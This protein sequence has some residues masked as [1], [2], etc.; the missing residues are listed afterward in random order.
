MKYTFSKETYY[1]VPTQVWFF[2][3]Y[4]A[5]DYTDCTEWLGGIAYRDVIICGECGG[6]V[7][8]EDLFAD[9]LEAFGTDEIICPM[10]WCNISEAITGDLHAPFMDTDYDEE[11]TDDACSK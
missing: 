9:A 7:F 6:E 2:N 11:D 3:S 10:S 8:I 4:G 1:D 5:Y